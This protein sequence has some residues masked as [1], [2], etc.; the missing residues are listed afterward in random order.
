MKWNSAILASLALG[1]VLVGIV[2]CNN[3]SAS[4]YGASNTPPNTQPNTVVM[5]TMSFSPNTMTVTRGTTVTWRN[6]DGATHTST[7]D[8]TGWD[9]GDMPPGTTRTTVFGTVGTFRYHCTYHRSMGMVGTIIV[10]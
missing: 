5:G 10:Q 3:D 7:S 1:V 6:S 4:S 9:T 8:S 2:G